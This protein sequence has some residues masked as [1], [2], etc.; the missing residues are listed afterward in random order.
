MKTYRIL[1]INPGS[2]S[3]K[4]ALYE[5][6]TEV[7]SKTLRHSNDELAPFARITD[8]FCFRKDIIMKEMKE[9]GVDIATLDAIVGRGG[10]LKPIPS[11]VY[12]VNEAMKNDLVEAAVEHASNLG[13]L[14][15]ADMAGGIDGCGAYIADPIV[16][17]EMEDVARVSGHPE[18]SRL[19]V[20]HALNQKAISRVYA[21][22]VG[23]KYEELNL[24]VAHMG[25]GISVGAH[26]KGRIVDVN[27]AIDGEGPFSPERAGTLPAGQLAALCFSGRYTYP[28]I[29]KMINGAGGLVAHLG[30]NEAHVAVKHALDGEADYKLIVDA[31]SYNVGKH[32]GA[33]AAVL[34]GRVDAIILTGGIAYNPMVTD[35]IGA[36]VGFIAP[37]R[38][39]A[40]EDEMK[41]L[42][43]N[44]LGVLTGKLEPKEY[45]RAEAE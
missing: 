8:Q 27:N 1:T 20:F 15:A 18:F 11:G 33:M 41:A 21:E 42:A 3:T 35:Y 45:G 10:F 9:Q 25:G 17:D 26:R 6:E 32:I 4:I 14:I 2:T 44:G 7:F 12:R 16:V 19:S 28:E 43:M 23:K 30:I 13:A 38:V 40:G 24:I 39:Y 34:G 29:K 5:G 22:S 31:M 36:M 37:V